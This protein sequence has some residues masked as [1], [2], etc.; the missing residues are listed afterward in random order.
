MYFLK[1]PK[2]SF[3]KLFLITA[4]NNHVIHVKLYRRKPDLTEGLHQ[5]KDFTPCLQVCFKSV[6]K[7]K[8]PSERSLNGNCCNHIIGAPMVFWKGAAEPNPELLVT[9]SSLG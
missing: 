9:Q 1:A 7:G 6:V 2:L 4:F 5:G 8:W 3:K